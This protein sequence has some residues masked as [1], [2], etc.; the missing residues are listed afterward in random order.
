VLLAKHLKID[1]K[2]SMRKQTIKNLVI[3]KLVDTNIFGEEILELKVESVDALKLKQLELDDVFKIKQ[4]EL[5]KQERE[6]K[7]EIEK[8][9]LEIKKMEMLEKEKQAEL[10]L[11]TK[12]AYQK[13]WCLLICL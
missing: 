4:L 8:Q 2:V 10:E 5:E 6:R 13:C 7:A 12:M 11:K 3:D 9:K 1:F